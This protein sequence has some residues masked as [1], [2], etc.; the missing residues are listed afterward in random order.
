MLA[1]VLLSGC[2]TGKSIKKAEDIQDNGKSNIVVFSYDVKVYATEKY[3]TVS[4]T[5][6]HFRCPEQSAFAGA[7]CFGISVP[8]KGRTELDGYLV[9]AFESAG[10]KVMRMKYGDRSVSGAFH[11][12]LVDKTQRISCV[13]DKK[14]RREVCRPN[15]EEEHDR[16]RVVFTEA[17][18]I[19]VNAGS[20]CYMGHL[21]M[22]MTD[23]E[24]REYEFDYEAQLT[25]DKLASLNEGIGGAV[26][27]FVNRPCY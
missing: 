6:L 1:V 8:Y 16:H 22:I 25:P 2:A 21:T 9:H 12:I 11:R 4:S 24:L 20:G 15:T 18:P 5:T 19:T 13:Y 10:T 27:Q 7:S 23:S 14:K 17:I 3:R 26:Q